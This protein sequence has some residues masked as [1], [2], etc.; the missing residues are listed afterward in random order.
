MEFVQNVPLAP[1]TTLGVG[2]PAQFFASA[3]SEQ[4]VTNGLSFAVERGLPVFIL[5]GGSNLLVADEGFPGLVLQISLKGAEFEADKDTVTVRAAAGEEWDGLVAESVR[6]NLQGIECLSGIPGLV[7]GTPVQNVGA[8]G[9]EVSETIVSVRALDR[10]E[11]KT[12]EL[13][14]AKC[15]FQYR[16]SIFNSTE[17]DRYIVLSVTYRLQPGGRPAVRYADLQRRFERTPEPTLQEVRDAVRDIRQS[18]GMLIVP[19]D[20]DCRSAGSFFKNPVI[21]RSEFER[22]AEEAQAAG[23][24][25]AGA[26]PPHYPAGEELVK[27]PAAWLIEHAGY[28]KGYSRGSVGLSSRH[29]LAIINRGGARAADVLELVAEITSRVQD[30]FGVGLKPEPVFVGEFR[31]TR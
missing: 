21:S 5:G 24:L 8:Y 27:L 20:P 28:R 23:M 11:G 15:E 9:Q 12:V 2:G 22:I 6:R 4:E 18:K 1:L 29:V 14:N 16:K 17:R 31:S 7:G 26:L 10:T 13:S 25:V 30:R 19:G 3:T